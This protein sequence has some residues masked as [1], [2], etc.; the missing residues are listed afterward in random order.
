MTMTEHKKEPGKCILMEFSG[1]VRALE[2]YCRKHGIDLSE[3]LIIALQPEVKTYCRE[4]RLNC[5]DTLPFFDNDSHRRASEKSHRLITLIR[6]ELRLDPGYPGYMDTFVYY[7]RFYLNNFVWIIEVLKGIKNRYGDIEIDV[8]EPEQVEAGPGSPFLLKKDRF[9]GTLAERYCRANNLGFKR[10]IGVSPTVKP[11][12]TK[13]GGTFHRLARR[14]T[15]A[16]FGRVLKKLS[17]S[18]RA[19]V[20]ITMPG[21]NLDRICRE[22]RARFPG[23]PFHCVTSLNGPQTSAGYLKR[24]VNGLRGRMDKEIIPVP[25]AVF[26]KTAPGGDGERRLLTGLKNSFDA[27]MNRWGEEFVYEN[28]SVKEAFYRKVSGDLCGHLAELYRTFTGQMKFLEYLKPKLSIS[29]VSTGAYQTMAQCGKLLGIPSLVIPQKGLVA[30]KTAPAQIEQSYIGKA[31]VT[32]D[33]DYAAAQSPMVY[34]YLKWAGYKGTIIQTGNLIFSKVDRSKRKEKRELF[35]PGIGEDKKIIVY[36]PSMKSRKSRRFYVLET[37]DELLSSIAD[38]AAAVSGIEDAHL[39]VRI[40]PAEPVKR[41]E[42]ETL[43]DLPSNVSVSDKGTFED[44]LTAAHLLISFS[45]TSIQEALLNRVPVVLYDKW[46]RYNHLEAPRVED[47]I[48]RN[49][50]AAY[51]IDEPGFLSSSLRWILDNHTGK[52]TR[53]ELFKDYIYP[54]DYREKFYD[55]VKQCCEAG[56]G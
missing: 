13:T 24:C 15:A 49:L 7:A 8:F 31:Q 11:E 52:E 9:A 40:H 36:A 2:D 6:E 41:S 33:F 32:E 47:S 10:L 50:S 43:I 54:G 29:P 3:F 48:P 20:F 26:E 5:T 44:I 12:S 16:V 46:K 21:Y 53:E 25:T 38:V 27:F 37:L 42:I 45:S 4:K 51:Y 1:D 17:Q 28:C 18:S 39:V 34:D 23:M 55:F 19:V 30:P 35:L 56:N 14:L 22:I